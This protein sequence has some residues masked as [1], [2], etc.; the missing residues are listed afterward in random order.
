MD[1]TA[2]NDD[3]RKDDIQIPN[4]WTILNAQGQLRYRS[5]I[6]LIDAYFQTRVQPEY[7]YHNCSKTP[8]GGFVTKAMLQGDM[9]APATFMRIM[10]HLMRDYL[11]EFVWVYINDILILSNKEDEHME[12]IKKVCRKL[13]EVHFFATGKNSE[14]L[15]PKMNVLGHVVDD[16]GL[17]A[18][19]AKITRIGE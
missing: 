7:E 12:H 8:F 15:S 2:R 5:K 14:F 1:L 18:S 16:D 17:H 19:P 4:Q 6:D 9:N 3:R 11:G 10:S 13:K